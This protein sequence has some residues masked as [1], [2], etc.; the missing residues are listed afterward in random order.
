MPF[1]KRL[2]IR[3]TSSISLN[4]KRLTKDHTTECSNGK[5]FTYWSNN[6]QL[7]TLKVTYFPTNRHTSGE[8]ASLW[9]KMD[10]VLYKKNYTKYKSLLMYL[11][12]IEHKW[13]YCILK[14][15]IQSILLIYSQLKIR[16]QLF[17]KTQSKLYKRIESKSI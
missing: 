14:N 9:S 11:K 17:M 3:T 16:N 10:Q 15:K 12:D 8:S 1:T 7:I 13:E 4:I 5:K 2:S 6:E